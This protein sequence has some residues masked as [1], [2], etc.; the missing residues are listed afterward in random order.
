M[1]TTVINIE[2]MSCDHCVKAVTTTVSALPGINKITV[3]LPTGTATIEYD[4][5]QTPLKTIKSEIEDQGFDTD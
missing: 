4:P 1:E 2:G 3:D 5:T